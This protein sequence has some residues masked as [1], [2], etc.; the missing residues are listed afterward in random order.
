MRNK[1][2]RGEDTGP[3]ARGGKGGERRGGGWAEAKGDEPGPG[4]GITSCRRRRRMV[5]ALWKDIK[6]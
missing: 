5:V 2:R 3:R 4:R 6:E 1:I